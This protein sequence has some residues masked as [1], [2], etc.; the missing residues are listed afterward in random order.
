[1]RLLCTFQGHSKAESF[2]AYLLTQKIDTNVDK[3]EGSEDAW[4]VWIREED[5]VTAAKNEYDRYLQDPTNPKYTEAIRKAADIRR[6]Q[7]I[8]QKEAARNIRTPRTM[9]TPA[10]QMRRIPPLTLTLTILC[11]IVFFLTNFGIEDPR[12]RLANGISDE[13][14]FVEYSDFVKSPSTP[15]ASI[16]K[17]E[18][19]R[20]ITPIFLHGSII[21]LLF[22]M[23][24]LV[25]L[26]RLVESTEGTGRFALIVLFIAI[27]SNLLQGLTPPS[28]FGLA[29]L[30]GTPLFVGM[31]GVVFGIF[32]LLWIKSTLRPDLG[33]TMNPTTVVIL[34]VWLAI[35]F[36]WPT[37][38]LKMAN[39]C[40]LG[41]LLSGMFLG[42]LL[43]NWNTAKRIR[44]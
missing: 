35:G 38:S 41:G 14:R 15:A 21:H 13:L 17:G 16:L 37:S 1:M 30:G 11:V 25:Q 6:E 10:A 26:G 44:N 22:N 4:E 24:M 8:K 29:F 31:S 5:Y 39:L 43:A 23:I 42:W 36:A 12:A 9:A 19:W 32:G 33:F 40:H 7:Q 27:V 20:L 3:V 28:P 18:I 34:L 2:T